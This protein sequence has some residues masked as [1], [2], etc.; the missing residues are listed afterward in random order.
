MGLGSSQPRCDCNKQF[1][2][3]N[4]FFKEFEKDERQILNDNIIK[5]EIA[6]WDNMPRDRRKNNRRLKQE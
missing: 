6:K 2:V 4:V 5:V 1:K 3:K